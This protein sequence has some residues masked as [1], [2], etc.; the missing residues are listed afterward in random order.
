MAR[1]TDAR[2]RGADEALARL[3]DEHRRC[4]D[5]LAELQSRRWLSPAEQA[6]EQRLKKLKLALRDE[7]EGRRR[8]AAR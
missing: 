6:E 8:G 7:I 2:E 3:L 4:E 1:V 5:E